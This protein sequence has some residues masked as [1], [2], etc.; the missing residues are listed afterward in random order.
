M[1]TQNALTVRG[2]IREIDPLESGDTWKKQEFTIV[3]IEKY[4]KE[5]RISIWNNTTE[6]LTRCKVGDI[7]ICSLNLQS[8]K[9]NDKW[10]SEISAWK[11]EVDIRAMIE[12]QKGGINAN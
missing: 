1:T 12:E 9:Y 11:V 7:V 4:P 2:Y 5:L 8:R 10:Y 6:Y 3:T